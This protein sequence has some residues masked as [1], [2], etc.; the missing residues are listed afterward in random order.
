M[1]LYKFGYSAAATFFGWYTLK[2]SYIL[3]SA[4]GGSGSIYSMF[5]DFPYITPPP[6]Y[7][8]YF[9][10]SMGYH[11]GSLLNHILAKKK[12]KDHLEMMFHHLI[13][14]YLYA[15]SYQT[16]TLI[17]PVIALIH[18]MSDILVNWTRTW[19]ETEY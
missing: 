13:T 7:R 12:Q 4:L 9:T 14:F 10:A 11:L 18:D 16:N 19:S 5:T 3:P 15:F 8:F 1:H 17:G 2:D 6:L